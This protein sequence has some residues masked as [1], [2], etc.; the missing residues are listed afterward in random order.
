MYIHVQGLG[1]TQSADHLVNEINQGPCNVKRENNLEKLNWCNG[2]KTM[3]RRPDDC[4][5]AK[6]LYQTTLFT[7]NIDGRQKTEAN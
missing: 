2:K 1:S 3:Q 6:W 7:T 5:V 4:L